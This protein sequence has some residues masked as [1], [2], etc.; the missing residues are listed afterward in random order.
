MTYPSPFTE[1]DT[2]WIWCACFICSH[3]V[4]CTMHTHIHHSSIYK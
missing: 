3:Y 2:V 1:H 4:V